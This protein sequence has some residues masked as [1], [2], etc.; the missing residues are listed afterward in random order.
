M[1]NL[2][3]D[4]VIAL[5]FVCFVLALTKFVTGTWRAVLNGVFDWPALR[6]WIEKEGNALVPIVVWVVLAKVIGLVNLD[7][8]GSAFG[9]PAGALSSLAGSGLMAFAGVQALTYVL[10]TVASIKDNLKP[11]DPADVRAKVQR[12]SNIGDPIPNTNPVPPSE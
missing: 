3:A 5:L 4:P 1:R 9:L 12:A 10:A 8:V 2:L 11:P 7:D 6:A